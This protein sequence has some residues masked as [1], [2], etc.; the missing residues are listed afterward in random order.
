NVFVFIL[1]SM[2]SLAMLEIGL[3]AVDGI[4]LFTTSNFIQQRIDVLVAQTLNQYDPVL[5][6]VLKPD[7]ALYCC[8]K[9]SFHTGEFG[10]RMNA[11]G[12]SWVA[13]NS[14]LAVGDSFTAGSDVGDAYTWP[15]HLER[16]LKKP[17]VNGA[18]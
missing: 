18:T 16:L 5:G 12:A 15:A 7:L 10:V 1:S 9:A 8:D 13:R 17:V 6:W 14:I 4:P 3:R 11:P 2:V